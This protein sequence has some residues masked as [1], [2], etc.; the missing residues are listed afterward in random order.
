MPGDVSSIS[1]LREKRHPSKVAQVFGISSPI[2]LEIK[3]RQRLEQMKIQKILFA[4]GISSLLAFTPLTLRAEIGGFGPQEFTF[5]LFGSLGTRD[6]EDFDDT[7]LGVGAGVNY[8]F[9][10]HFGVGADT[11]LEEIDI[12]NH[13][14]LSVI[15]RW[16]IETANVAPY[17]FAGF[18]RQWHDATQWTTHLGIG[19]EYRPAGGTCGI[20]V[21]A[22]SVF[23]DKTKDFGVFRA[24]VRFGF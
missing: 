19:A 24:G 14:D 20:F 18:G 15:G 2:N 11:Y 5:D 21:D 10:T 22:R 12:P 13:L 7:Q 23:A 8:F 17:V 9:T 1:R 3:K 4:I 16:P 6:R